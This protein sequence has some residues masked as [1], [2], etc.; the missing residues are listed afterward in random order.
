M[1]SY[2]QKNQKRRRTSERTIK[3]IKREGPQESCADH[4][5]VHASMKK[6]SFSPIHVNIQISLL[7]FE[8]IVNWVIL[9]SKVHSC[10]HHLNLQ[11]P[12]W[13]NKTDT[14]IEPLNHLNTN[15]YS[16]TNSP[17]A[18]AR[19]VKIIT[20]WMNTSLSKSFEVEG[21]LKLFKTSF[22]KLMNR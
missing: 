12:F 5:H 21:K 14:R 16:C 17:F 22:K 9:N 2:N 6:K 7:L 11:A 8:R 19:F 20:S 15:Y 1:N 3:R 13:W 4:A 10:S 18:G